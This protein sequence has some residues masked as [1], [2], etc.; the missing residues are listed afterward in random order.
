MYPSTP[1]HA[2]PLSSSPLAVL[3]QASN[4][5]PTFQP[6]FELMPAAASFGTLRAGCLYRLPF[7]LINVSAIPQVRTARPKIIKLKLNPAPENKKQATLGGIKPQLRPE[8]KR[9]P[10]PHAVA[11]LQRFSLRGGS[12]AFKV[13][14]RPGVAASGMSVPIE[15]EIGSEIELELHEVRQV[16]HTRPNTHRGLGL[17]HLFWV[18]RSA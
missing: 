5:A 10:R 7:K 18:T 8:R 6:A 11:A 4:P 2:P 16:H 9:S 14:Y 12:A 3:P 17:S 1:T 15:V 13:I